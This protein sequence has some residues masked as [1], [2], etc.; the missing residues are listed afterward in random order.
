M[1]IPSNLWN[2]G[3]DDDAT[4]TRISHCF[5]QIGK[6]DDVG[7]GDGFD[8]LDDEDDSWSMSAGHSAAEIGKGFDPGVTGLIGVSHPPRRMLDR[9]Y[10]YDDFDLIE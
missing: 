10:Y 2:D 7:V 3:D 1:E 6:H 4:E 9:S 8:W 5:L